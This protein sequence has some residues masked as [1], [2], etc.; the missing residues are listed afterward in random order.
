M[1]LNKYLIET[2]QYN[3]YANKMVL[4]KVELLPDQSGCIK[5]FSH[6]INC[7]YK[8]LDRI[9]IYPEI[10]KLDWWL[11]L[12]AF[13]ELEKEWDKSLSPWIA[14]LQNKT[15]NE[16]MQEVKWIG[17]EN[18]TYTAQLKDIALQLNYH[19]IHHRAQMQTI[20]R[21]QGLEPDFVD[22]IAT[23]YRIVE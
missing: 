13:D 18:A 21:S 9:N 11:P 17:A 12:Y 15:E 8:W 20:I 22:Y 10:S 4:K 16:L 6:L 23:K 5:F 14:L 2:F 1:D 19:S 7:Q 3:G